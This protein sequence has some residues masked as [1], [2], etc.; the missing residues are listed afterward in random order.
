MA[1]NFIKKQKHIGRKKGAEPYEICCPH[2]KEGSGTL[3]HYGDDKQQ[4]KLN[5]IA[6]LDGDEAMFW[7][8]SVCHGEFFD[9][10]VERH[11]FK[12]G[13]FTNADGELVFVPYT[14]NY[15]AKRAAAGTSKKKRPKGL[16][17]K[18]KKMLRRLKK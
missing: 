10:E 12:T 17:W 18:D 1:A 8:C 9:D 5:E 11:Y 6:G 13:I 2:C 4:K 15:I 7:K 3:T 16:S 14:K